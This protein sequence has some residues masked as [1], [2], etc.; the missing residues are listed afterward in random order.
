VARPAGEGCLVSWRATKTSGY[1]EMVFTT[2]DDTQEKEYG[3]TVTIPPTMD[4]ANPTKVIFIAGG[5]ARETEPHGDDL[6]DA[7]DIFETNASTVDPKIVTVES[8][9]HGPL[10][11]YRHSF[12]TVTTAPNAARTDGPLGNGDVAWSP[13]FCFRSRFFAIYVLARGINAGSNY[14]PAKRL[15]A[16]YDALT[17]KVL[18]RR[19]QATE[20]RNLG[21]PTP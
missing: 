9:V 10:R 16:V 19:W 14:A 3:T 15:E 6:S 13:R 2:Q 7:T 20:L 12:D 17:D 11:A 4:P 1:Y 8:Y 18:W 5:A 21:D